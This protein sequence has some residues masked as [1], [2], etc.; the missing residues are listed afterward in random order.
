MVVAA[1]RTVAVV[2]IPG[3][4]VTAAR[5]L[6]AKAAR[7]AAVMA[8]NPPEGRKD[9]QKKWVAARIAGPKLGV[10]QDYPEIIP[11]TYVR[12]TCVPPSTMANGTRSAAP[13]IRHEPA[14]RLVTS[15]EKPAAGTPSAEPASPE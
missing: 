5:G 7:N 15:E 4:E 1:D 10:V 8:V 3:E 13:E 14:S 2:S 11:Q 6:R 12:R 9:D